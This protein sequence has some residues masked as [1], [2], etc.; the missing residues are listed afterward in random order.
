MITEV[1][2]GMFFYQRNFS[3]ALALLQKLK[4]DMLHGENGSP[5]PKALLEGICYFFTNDKAKAR[6]AMERAR[7]F[8]EQQVRENPNDAGHH[9]QLGVIFAALGRKEDA[10]QEGKRA[11]ELLPESKD[12]FDGPAM[13]IELAQIYT[14]TG[15]IDL[16][17]QLIE[18]SLNTPAGITA[19]LLKIDPVWDPLRK[20]PRFQ[21]LIDKYSA[22]A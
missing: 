4:G 18:H 2:V 21:A 5:T 14:W 7:V 13:T 3:E 6:E 19:P 17:L 10:I 15:E 16:A 9:A 1:R 12:A 22:K 20:D 11:T 8:V